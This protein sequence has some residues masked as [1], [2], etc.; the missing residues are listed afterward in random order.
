MVEVFYWKN[1]KSSD[2]SGGGDN[3]I[4][5]I[6]NKIA[7]YYVDGKVIL[8]FHYYCEGM[9]NSQDNDIEPTRFSRVKKLINTIVYSSIE[10]DKLFVEE[11]MLMCLR[12]YYEDLL[13]LNIKVSM[14][15]KDGYKKFYPIEFLPGVSRHQQMI[16]NSLIKPKSKFLE[17]YGLT[18][19]TFPSKEEYNNI[20]STLAM[21]NI[22]GINKGETTPLGFESISVLYSHFPSIMLNLLDR[23]YHSLSSASVEEKRYLM[24]ELISIRLLADGIYFFPD[25]EVK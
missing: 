12:Y 13:L 24:I 7:P 3:F 9:S 2:F 1:L 4:D 19:S 14:N 21:E 16:T 6:F 17:S 5:V 22:F 11:D 8:P 10:D 15:Y 25:L 20:V 23:F 18:C